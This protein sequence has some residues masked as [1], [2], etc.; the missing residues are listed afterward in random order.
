MWSEP[1]NLEFENAVAEIAAKLKIEPATFMAVAMVESNGVTGALMNGKMEPLIR[2]EGHYFFKRLSGLERVKGRREGLASPVAGAVQNPNGQAARW[3]MLARARAINE[4][5]ALESCSWGLGQVMGAH[6][7]WLGYE[8]V[9]ALVAAARSGVAGQLDLMA[10]FIEKSG[11]DLALRNKDWAG[12]AVGYNGPNFRQ[13]GYDRKLREAYDKY[14]LTKPAVV[15]AVLALGSV[16]EDVVSLQI[17]L[18]AAGFPVLQSG[19][20]DAVTE[21]A[22]R[23]FQ[24]QNGLVADGKVGEVTLAALAGAMPKGV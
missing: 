11:L 16:G 24:R 9:A 15:S 23:A 8:S 21:D 7:H 22:V 3:Q 17:M 18:T 1:M 14:A 2:F 12:F 13:G 5:A 20:F 19:V 6:W 4:V 10:R